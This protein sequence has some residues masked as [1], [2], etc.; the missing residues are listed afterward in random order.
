MADRVY[1]NYRREDDT[2]DAVQLL[3]RHLTSIL[4]QSQVLVGPE[5]T[6]EEDLIRHISQSSSVLVVIGSKWLETIKK[7]EHGP[8]LVRRAIELAFA[9][10]KV[11][12]P[13]C[14]EYATIPTALQLPESIQML[15]HQVKAIRLGSGLF[16]DSVDDLVDLLSSQGEEHYL[17]PISGA[18]D[19]DETITLL[20]LSATREAQV[21]S[22]RVVIYD[23]LGVQLR[24]VVFD[25]GDITIGRA[26]ENDIVLAKNNISKRH[27]RIVFGEGKLTAYDLHSTNGTFGKRSKDY[28]AS[29]HQTI[30]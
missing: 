20:D 26:E 24:D 15:S 4:G 16:S 23:D 25:E 7:Y 18:S 3:N 30:G 6:S 2:E 11:V 9:Y 27:C 1:I 12:I 22:F 29:N 8:D 28:W 14:I 5:S 21:L 13:V 10:N 19:S 17:L